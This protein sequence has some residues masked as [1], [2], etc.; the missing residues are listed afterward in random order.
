[1]TRKGKILVLVMSAAI[2]G[3]AAF[4]FRPRHPPAAVERAS[5]TP[6]QRAEMQSAPKKVELKPGAQSPAPAGEDPAN[7]DEQVFEDGNGS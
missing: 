3:A 2:F 7:T 1:M 4:A 6:E 5:L